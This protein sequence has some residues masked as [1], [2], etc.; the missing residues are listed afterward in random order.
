MGHASN[1]ICSRCGKQFQP[2]QPLNLCDCGGPLLV[3]YDLRSVRTQWSKSDLKNAINSMWRYSPVLPCE[4]EEAVTLQEGWTPLVRATALQECLN[5]RNLW[6]KDEGR[7][8]TGSFK[9]RGL[10]CA[11]SMAKKIGLRKLAIPYAGNAGSALAAY[12]A[13]G[14]LQA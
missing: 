7:N 2:N 8:P 12:D 5:A 14:N 6:V 1:L 3:N 4:L 11:V 10:S 9:A 13:A